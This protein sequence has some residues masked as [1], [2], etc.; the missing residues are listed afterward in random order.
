MINGMYC[1][2]Y[3]EVVIDAILR[4]LQVK[5]AEAEGD[6]GPRGLVDGVHTL[7]VGGVCVGVGG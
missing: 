1:P 3:R 7:F 6:G 4:T 2:P 5:C